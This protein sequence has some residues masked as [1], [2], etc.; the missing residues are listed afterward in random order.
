[1]SRDAILSIGNW[2]WN[3]RKKEF[4]MCEFFE[5]LETALSRSTSLDPQVFVP[6]I[7]SPHQVL[8]EFQEGALATTLEGISPSQESSSMGF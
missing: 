6:G 2:N 1:M 3:V 4:R 7:H 8:G 5:E